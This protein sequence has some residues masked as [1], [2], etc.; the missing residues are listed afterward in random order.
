MNKREDALQKAKEII[1]NNREEEYGTPQESLGRV[2][3]YWSV[4]LNR[5][6]SARD[7]SILLNLMKLARMDTG[8]KKMII[9]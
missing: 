2:A 9:I 4:F 3:K 1:C 8:I 7:V 5:Q 6:I